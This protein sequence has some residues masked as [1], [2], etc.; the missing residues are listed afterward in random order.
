MKDFE[1]LCKGRNKARA[2][3]RAKKAIWG[4][5]LIEILVVVGILAVLFVIAIFFM[6]RHLMRSRDAQRKADLDKIRF[7][8]EEYYNDHRCYPLAEVL[9]ACGS[10]EFA[11]YLKEIPCD[12]LNNRPYLAEFIGGD[13][14]AG[15]RVLTSLEIKDDIQILSIGCDPNTGCGW[16]DPSYN[17][18][19][20]TGAG[21]GDNVWAGGLT[22][23]DRWYCIDEI[24]SPVCHRLSY[25]DL[26]G[27]YLCTTSYELGD[28]DLCEQECEEAED[29]SDVVCDVWPQSE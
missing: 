1:Q 13:N 16:T 8:F 10:S 9:L 23:I 28:G 29:P 21:V 7:A 22:A 17:Y 2:T 14:C 25:N 18:G 26:M 15:Y 6:Q 5:S 27:R 3:T 19:V 24:G 20:S 4:I 12:P 11:P